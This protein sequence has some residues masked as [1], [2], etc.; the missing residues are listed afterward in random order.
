MTYRLTVAALLIGTTLISSVQANHGPGTSGG[1]SATMS[2]ETLKQGKFDL[3]FRTD[4][5]QFE[6]VSEAGAIRRAESSGGFDGLDSSAIYSGSIA[7]GILDNLQISANLG[8]YHGSGFISA[9]PGEDS[10]DIEVGHGD[11]SGITDLGLQL[12]YRLLSGKPGNLSV[13]G[14][15]IVPT[16]RDGYKLDTG[17]TLEPSSQPGTGAWAYQFGLAYSRFLT[18]RLTTDLSALYTLRTPHDGFEVGDRIDLGAALAYRLTE[19]VSSFPNYS[20]FGELNA[21][22]LGKDQGLGEYNEN[23]GGWT[24]YATP[25]FRVRFNENTALTVA[26][27]IPILQDLNGDQIESRFKLAATLSFSF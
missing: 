2:G 7:Y 17:E 20:V 25:G 6:N 23:S 14:G 15:L 1:A 18:P 9:E 12:K 10:P 13:V 4:Y 26:P 27:S 21:I 5:T 11:P 3:S 8:Y 24:V 19:Q 16:G 22:W